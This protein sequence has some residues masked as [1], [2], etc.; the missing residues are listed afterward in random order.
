MQLIEGKVTRYEDKVLVLVGKAKPKTL[1]DI[2]YVEERGRK[3][4]KTGRGVV[5][6]FFPAQQTRRTVRF[7]RRLFIAT[8]MELLPLNAPMQSDAAPPP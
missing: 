4:I 5:Q 7:S 3:A 2:G 6:L 1:D 8:H